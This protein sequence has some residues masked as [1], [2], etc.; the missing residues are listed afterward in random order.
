MTNKLKQRQQEESELLERLQ[1]YQ[2]QAQDA[3]K[4]L[5]AQTILPQASMFN[6]KSALET[7][8]SI[9][10]RQKKALAEKSI[11]AAH[12]K[13][14]QE[15]VQRLQD[16]AVELSKSITCLRADKDAEI[17]RSNDA[18]LKWM[19]E[20]EKT[21]ARLKNIER[22]FRWD[23]EANKLYQNYLRQEREQA[24]REEEEERREREER[25]RKEAEQ[26]RLE[27]EQ[28]EK[29]ERENR[30]YLERRARGMGMFR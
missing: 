12:N 14:L 1:S 18:M 26:A 25:E 22:F 9:I 24:E 8:R 15:K 21:S 5:S 20:Y 10:E 17:K 4:E 2:Q 29:R 11:V 3:E 23:H 7:A 6:F 16:E 28:D 19:K 27:K 30:E 13:K